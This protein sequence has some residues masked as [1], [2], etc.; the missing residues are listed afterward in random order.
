MI[1]DFILENYKWLLEITTI[2]QFSNISNKFIIDGFGGLKTIIIIHFTDFIDV[3]NLKA[4]L[5]LK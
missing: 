4:L 2:F 1:Y 5:L 3:F